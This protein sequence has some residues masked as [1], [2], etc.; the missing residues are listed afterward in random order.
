MTDRNTADEL[1]ASEIQ[2]NESKGQ[3]YFIN[4]ANNINKPV[5]SKKC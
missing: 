3:G 1:N 4:L 5:L 2:I